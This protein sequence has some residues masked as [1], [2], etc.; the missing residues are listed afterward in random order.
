MIQQ[1]FEY[2]LGLQKVTPSEVFSGSPISH[3]ITPISHTITPI[4]HTI[5][6]ISHTISESVEMGVLL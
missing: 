5:T 3:T 6:P 2:Y 1:M 4:S